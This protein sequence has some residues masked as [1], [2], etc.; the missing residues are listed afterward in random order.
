MN[1]L[2]FHFLRTLAYSNVNRDEDGSPKS[3]IF[4]GIKRWRVS[5]QSQ[6]R[7]VL[8]DLHE[9]D[10]NHFDGK[11][12]R[13]IRDLFEQSLIKCGVKNGNA[14][15]IAQ[16][17]AELIGGKNN[18][19]PN[20]TQ[21][22]VKIS[23]SE[24]EYISSKIAKSISSKEEKKIFGKNMIIKNAILKKWFSD[25]VIRGRA[26]I[27]LHGRML[28]GKENFL[29]ELSIEGAASYGHAFTTHSAMP[30]ID[31]FSAVDDCQP[32][33]DTGSAHIDDNLY[34]S[35]TF[36]HPTI[37]DLTLFH[38]NSKLESTEFLDA[39]ENYNRSMIRAFPSGKKN[40]AFTRD[41]PSYVIC[42]FRK[43]GVPQSLANAFKDPIRGSNIE[44][45]SWKQMMKFWE[46]KKKQC[47]SELG[48][49]ILET[50]F[51]VYPEKGI[52]IDKFCEE[53]INHVKKEMF[54]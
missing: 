52:S 27:S 32:T 11:N 49:S 41:F 13:H 12:T 29:S 5:S 37:I 36:Y 18:K 19:T 24:I 20:I 53:I 8:V 40:S 21:T 47:G 33:E 10:V 39:L 31:F 28:T 15:K 34:S 17:I 35:G 7:A 44:D 43:N 48:N 9:K 2:E 38:K 14:S 23:S 46:D 51:S 3:C 42:S 22:L 26:D 50:V 1:F 45:K 6:K 54:K 25:D 30:E 16:G 4:N